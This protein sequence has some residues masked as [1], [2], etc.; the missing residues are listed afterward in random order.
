MPHL[1]SF[2][3]FARTATAIGALAMTFALVPAET[4]LQAAQVLSS[5]GKSVTVEAKKGSLVRLNQPASTVFIA[6]PEVCDVQVKSPRLIYLMGKKPGQ[7]TLIAVDENEN[8]LA[9]MDVTVTQDLGRLN[10]AINALYPDSGI[11]VSSVEQ[12]VVIDGVVG[13]PSVSEDV[14]KL[15]SQ[16]VGKETDI[17]NRLGV[18][19]PTQINLRVRF[20]EMSR[21]TEK[22]LGINWSI[23][24]AAGKTGIAF[25]TFNPLAIAGV[26]SD[27]L[28]INTSIG[29]TDIN[30]LLDI[31]D[32]EGMASILAEPNLTALSGET[33]SFLAG[34]E[35]PIPIPQSD[36]VVT[37]EF[38]KF[39][40]SLSF[41][42]T[43]LTGNRI[44]LRVAPEVSQLSNNGAIQIQN[45]QIP[46][47][48]TR[49]AETMVEA[50][51][52]QSIVIAGLLM[53]NV[54][55]DVNKVP[56]L[57]DVPVLGKLFTSENFQRQETEL[58]II[59]TPYIVGA[60]R[61]EPGAKLAP[62]PGAP[63]APGPSAAAPGAP[64]SPAAARTPGKLVGPGG[65]QLD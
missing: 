53:N 45:F 27:S 4:P 2:S 50:A 19:A 64:A 52:G 37:I 49:R 46:A 3:H 20:A 38:K 10:Q 32:Q 25:A 55:R 36:G 1:P 35:F 60:V 58:V 28:A 63:A 14:R 65:F 7:T 56:W 57:S 59:V 21:E 51:S 61:E 47:L 62:P 12:S 33:A 42:P 15:A 23:V 31:L 8:I 9:N 24:N 22:A 40:V 39:G 16:F 6:D 26:L 13:S 5:G 41:T 18:D 34:G 43:I 44:N 30:I 48:I 17:I 29:K 11:N 54:V